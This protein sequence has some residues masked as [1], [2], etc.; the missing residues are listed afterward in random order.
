MK[1]AVCIFSCCTL[2]Y[3]SLALLF[4][5]MSW[6]GANFM[7]FFLFLMLVVQIVLTSIYIVRKK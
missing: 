5:L 4:E 2:I 1:Y 3:M 6:P 7:L